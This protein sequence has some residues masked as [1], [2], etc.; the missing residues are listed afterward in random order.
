[1]EWSSG[2]AAVRRAF[3]ELRDR[4][5]VRESAARNYEWSVLRSV[6]FRGRGRGSGSVGCNGDWVM[7]VVRGNLVG[8]CVSDIVGVRIGSGGRGVD[9]GFS[10]VF[11]LGD[12]FTLH[13][14]SVFEVFE[15]NNWSDKRG[16]GLLMGAD[17]SYLCFMEHVHRCVLLLLLLL[18]LLFLFCVVFF[19]VLRIFF[20]VG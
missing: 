8:M 15:F 3:G 18:L 5:G 13:R 20:L 10:E 9:W 7:S 1:M 12:Q 14:G 11:L 16:R 4:F 2:G 17:V 6:T 19:F